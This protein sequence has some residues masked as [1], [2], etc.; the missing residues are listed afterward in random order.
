MW[1]SLYRGGRSPTSHHHLGFE[2][3]DTEW[4]EASGS[5]WERG[6]GGWLRRREERV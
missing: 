3:G 5:G 2:V 1:R 6:I 4:T